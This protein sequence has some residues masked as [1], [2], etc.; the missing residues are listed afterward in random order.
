VA[1][2]SEGLKLEAWVRRV[3]SSGWTPVVMPLLEIARA[4]GLLASQI[5]LLGQPL[6]KG[7]ASEA[8]LQEMSELLADPGKIEQLIERFEQATP[9]TADNGKGG[10]LSD[11][12]RSG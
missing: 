9:S 6:Y 10:P 8:T 7:S 11:Q 4:L 3:E 12:R 2:S 1:E 5:I